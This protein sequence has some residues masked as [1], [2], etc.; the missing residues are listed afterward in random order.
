MEVAGN[1]CRALS[2]L[3]G[4]SGDKEQCSRSSATRREGRDGR[5]GLGQRTGGPRVQGWLRLVVSRP[6]RTRAVSVSGVCAK[7][8]TGVSEADNQDERIFGSR[9]RCKTRWGKGLENGK[10][11]GG[12]RRLGDARGERTKTAAVSLREERGGHKM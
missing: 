7:R 3:K 2:E 8:K 4:P 10:A 5:D 1:V 12:K 9:S 6:R 11:G